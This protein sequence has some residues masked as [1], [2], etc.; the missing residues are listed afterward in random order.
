VSPGTEPPYRIILSG[1]QLPQEPGTII[2]GSLPGRL[3]DAWLE[4]FLVWPEGG[5]TIDA[6]VAFGAFW[7]E[8]I[9]ASLVMITLY[10]V[11]SGIL[12]L[13]WSDTKQ[14]DV[15]ATGYLDELVPFERPGTY[16]L[17]VTR[18]STVLAWGVAFMGQR[19]EENCSGG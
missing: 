5:L 16:R 3:S 13:V 11:E 7:G 15:D 1:D 17:E 9:G 4:P 8:P 12:D 14:I 19:C 18:D 2:F 6:E 10:Q